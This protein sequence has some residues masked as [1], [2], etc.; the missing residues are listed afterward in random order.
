VGTTYY[1]QQHYTANAMVCR[2]LDS[3]GTL[4]AT[5]SVGLCTMDA[6]PSKSLSVSAA[7]RAATIHHVRVFEAP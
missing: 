3:S 2:L 7:S 6:S 1:L 4:V 5:K